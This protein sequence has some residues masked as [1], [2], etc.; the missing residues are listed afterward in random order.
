ML[1][2]EGQISGRQKGKQSEGKD[3][4]GKGER[5]QPAREEKEDNMALDDA[6]LP[7]RKGT[8]ADALDK[9]GGKA[10]DPEHLAPAVAPRCRLGVVLAEYFFQAED[11]IRDA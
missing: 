4:T 9:R 7:R 3:P 6:N 1:R 2:I 11:G 8:D 10:S 5:G